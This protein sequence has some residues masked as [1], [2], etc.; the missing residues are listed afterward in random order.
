[1]TT[2]IKPPFTLESAKEKVKNAD[3]LWNSK[4]PQQ[5]ALAYSQDSKWRNRDEFIQ[6]RREIVNFLTHKWRREFKYSLKKQLFAFQ[7][8]RIAVHFE[9]EYCDESNKWHRAYGNENWDFDDEGLMQSRDA[10]INEI[11]IKEA[12]RRIF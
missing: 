7:E 8:N 5:I 2:E 11:T 3:K 6:G 10:S 12:D 1:M 4:N 9:Y